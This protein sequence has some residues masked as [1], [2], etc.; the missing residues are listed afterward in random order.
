MDNPIQALVLNRHQYGETSLILRL[1]TERHGLISGVL[2]GA[3]GKK[4]WV[5]EI[6]SIIEVNPTR[7]KDEGLYTLSSVEYEYNYSFADSLVKSA[8]RDTAF[9]LSLAVLHEEEPQSELYLLFGKFLHHIETCSDHE[10]LFSLWLFILRFGDSL[11]VPVIR[12]RCVM[13]GDTLSDGGE[14]TP[15]QG[16]FTCTSCRPGKSPLFGGALISLLATG[17]PTADELI[18]TLD[19]REKMG[20]TTYL[21]ENLRNSFEFHRQINSLQFLREVV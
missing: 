2:K 5:P 18:P 20:V 11:G 13:C 12:D 3:L 16:G 10:A 21:I 6:G 15:E 14:L 1:F 9:E 4:K 19:S 8:I 17:N 7:K